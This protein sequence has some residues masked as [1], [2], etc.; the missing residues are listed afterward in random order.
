MAQRWHDLLFAHWAV[1]P[2]VVRALVPAVLPLDL[3]DGRAWIGVVPFRMSGVRPRLVPSLLRLSAFAELNVRTY[4]TLGDKPG[5]YFFSLDAASALAVASARALFHLPYYRAAMSLVSDGEA[6]CYTSRRTHGGATPAELRVRYGPL[7]PACSA[8][9]GSL[10]EW[11]T[12]RY[13]LYTVD[14]Q[15]RPR[16]CEIH[17]APWPLQPA[18]ARFDRNTMTAA[19]GI[20]LPDEPPL[21]HFARSLDVVVWPLEVV[22]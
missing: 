21:L 9:P 16:R 14:R 7:G 4:V 15:G 1:E 10:D 3:R 5:V 20:A 19:A 11:L 12:A 17:H 8:A 13:C 22:T 2:A 6:I 18:E